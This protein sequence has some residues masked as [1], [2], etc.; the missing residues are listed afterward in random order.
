MGLILFSIVA[1]FFLALL[2]G[3]VSLMASA[4]VEIA[5]LVGFIVWGSCIYIVS[6]SQD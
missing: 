2:F 4:P 1:G 5:M 6:N 3:G